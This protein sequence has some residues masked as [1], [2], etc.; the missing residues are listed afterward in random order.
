MKME[1][2][3]AVGMGV[4]EP[5][6]KQELCFEHMTWK[7]CMRYSSNVD[8]ICIIKCGSADNW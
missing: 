7:M 2:V 1:T 3:E 6:G 8:I 5:L 4:Q